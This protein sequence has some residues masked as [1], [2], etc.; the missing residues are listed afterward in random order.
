MSVAVDHPREV[1]LSGRLVNSPEIARALSS[2]LSRFA[3]VRR[4]GRKATVAKEAAE[5]AYLIGEGLRGGKYRELVDTMELNKAR[6]TM[7]DYVL[8]KGFKNMNPR[9]ALGKT[10]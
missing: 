4:V 9:P 7:F 1:L 8:L 10:L 5:G 3:P 2:G 6:G